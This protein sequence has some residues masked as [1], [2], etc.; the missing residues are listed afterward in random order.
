[1][2]WRRDS[3]EPRFLKVAQPG[4]PMPPFNLR[5]PTANRIERKDNADPNQINDRQTV[6]VIRRHRRRTVSGWIG[7]Q[8][9]RASVAAVSKNDGQ[10]VDKWNVKQII[11]QRNPAKNRHGFEP[12]GRAA[13]E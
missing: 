1:D 4:G 3:V 5:E 11:K 10:S 7:E 13:V 6:T 2:R 8:P 12:P 9:F